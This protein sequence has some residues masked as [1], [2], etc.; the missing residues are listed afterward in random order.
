MH[1]LTLIFGAVLLSEAYSLICHKCLPGS[2]ATCE[3]KTCPSV[4]YQCSVL[5]ITSY[6]GGSKLSDI[7]MKTC[8]LNEDC[9]EGS[10]NFGLT[11]N[12]ITSKCCNSNLCNTETAPEP[13]ESEPNGKKCFHCNGNVCT[14]TV[15]CLGN[16][17]HCISKTVNVGG[18]TIITKG[19][20]SKQICSNTK[21]AQFKGVIGGDISCCEGDYCNS[22][23]STS[24]GLL[25]L[26]TPLI[27]LVMFS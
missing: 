21:N 25:L 1:L 20:A 18:E 2:T 23:S 14:T 11:R 10:V 3:F 16:E 8:V 19:C 17:D 13:S 27:S 9:A 4:G 15:N 24:A 26:V 22:A 6:A 7:Q 12:V 5:R